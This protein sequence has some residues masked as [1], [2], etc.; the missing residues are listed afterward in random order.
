MRQKHTGRA[1][2]EKVGTPRPI[3]FCSECD[4]SSVYKGNVSKHEQTKHKK[5]ISK[6]MVS[7]REHVDSDDSM[8]EETC[9]REH[10]ADMV[11]DDN[12][13]RPVRENV[14]FQALFDDWD[15]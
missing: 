12:I 15:D 13:S 2:E 6:K 9:P 11:L 14:S 7:S 8:Q 4:Y 3:H 5:V 10:E 1:G